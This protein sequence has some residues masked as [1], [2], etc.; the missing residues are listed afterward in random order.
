MEASSPHRGASGNSHAVEASS[1]HRGAS[2]NS[3]A[4]EASSPHLGASGNSRAVSGRG[5]QPRALRMAVFMVTAAAQRAL[6]DTPDHE[7]TKIA[8]ATLTDPNGTALGDLVGTVIAGRNT[9]ATAVVDFIAF[10]AE[11]LEARAGAQRP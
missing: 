6:A 11:R 9:A 4:V 7:P 3:H 2:G 1:P 5:K 8:Y 10:V